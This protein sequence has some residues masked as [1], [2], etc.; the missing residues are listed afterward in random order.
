MQARERILLR[1]RDSMQILCEDIISDNI[2]V[3]TI[4]RTVRR[5][6]KC[7]APA[8]ERRRRN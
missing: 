5:D 2:N 6:L 4:L 3:A 7:K 8:S 1:L